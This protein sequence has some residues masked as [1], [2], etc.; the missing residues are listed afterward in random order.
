MEAILG[1]M[2]GAE[3][4]GDENSCFETIE[5]EIP[6]YRNSSSMTSNLAP[7][8]SNSTTSLLPRSFFFR[9]APTLLK[10]LFLKLQFR[11]QLKLGQRYDLSY[12]I[13]IWTLSNQ[14]P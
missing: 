10:C 12:Q 11:L 4:E 14:F 7:E 13:K 3:L 2:G 6:C 8:D 1:S 9:T 5:I